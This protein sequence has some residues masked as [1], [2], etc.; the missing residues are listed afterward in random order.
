MVRSISLLKMAIMRST[1]ALPL[2]RQLSSGIRRSA[3]SSPNNSGGTDRH[4]VT[5]A[6]GADALRSIYQVGGRRRVVVR[7]T[8]ARIGQYPAVEDARGE[9]RDAAPSAGREQAV[10]GAGVKQRVTARHKHAV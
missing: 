6:H 3:A 8:G 4:T 2:D 10:R 9:H 5:C 7:R 1:P